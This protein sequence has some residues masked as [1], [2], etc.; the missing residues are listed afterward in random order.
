MTTANTNSIFQGSMFS[1]IKRRDYAL[2][3]RIHHWPAP[4]WLRWTLIYSSKGGDGWLWYTLGV[5]ILIFGDHLRFRAVAAGLVATGL[6]LAIYQI[7]KKTTRRKRPCLIEPHEWAGV[8]PPDQYS[9]PSGHTIASFAIATSVGLFYPSLMPAL[10]CCAI[11]IATSRIMLGM[12]FLSDVLVGVM[13]GTALGYTAFLF[14][15]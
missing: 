7:V 11:M 5:V 6:G 9:F 4:D 1:F 14:I 10:F 8:Q 15:H 2:M 3:H 13:I 12:H